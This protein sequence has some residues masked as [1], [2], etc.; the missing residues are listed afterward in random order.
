MQ[1]LLTAQLALAG[2]LSDSSSATDSALKRSLTGATRAAVSACRAL[3]PL[4]QRMHA[5]QQQQQQQAIA[6][7]D[8]VDETVLDLVCWC[9]RA[10]LPELTAAAWDLLASIVSPQSSVSQQHTVRILMNYAVF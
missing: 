4:S 10:P 7:N 3:K 6:V 8:A 5:G 2:L 9:A 1:V